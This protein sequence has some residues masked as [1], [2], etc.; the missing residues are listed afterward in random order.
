MN[1]STKQEQ[2]YRCRKQTYGYQGVRWGGWINWKIGIDVYTLLYMKQITNKNLLYSTGDSAQ[3]S[4]MPI[5]EK[6][7][8][9]SGYINIYIYI[10]I[11]MSV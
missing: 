7:L 8:K 4:V 1:L 11:H 10:Y 6:N 2:S 9:K 3:Y 5:W